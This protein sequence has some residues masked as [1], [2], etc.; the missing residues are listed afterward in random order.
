MTQRRILELA[1]LQAI[2]N[3][4]KEREHLLADKD[5]GIL[6]HRVKVADKELN[7]IRQLYK[8]AEQKEATL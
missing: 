2:N 5:N 3:W 8:E 1:Y 6:R 4:H 7:E